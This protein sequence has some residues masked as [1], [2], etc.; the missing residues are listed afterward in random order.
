MVQQMLAELKIEMEIRIRGKRVWEVCRN[1]TEVLCFTHVR[2]IA[3]NFSR[4]ATYI[5]LAHII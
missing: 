3:D 4:L 5:I 2:R 1:G